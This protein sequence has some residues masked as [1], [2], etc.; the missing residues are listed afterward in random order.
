MMFLSGAIALPCGAVETW[1]KL[2]KRIKGQIF[3]LTVGVKL[4]LRDGLWANLA[5][6]SPKGH[7][8]VFSTGEDK[9]FKVIS[10]GTSFPIHTNL[11]DKTYFLTS[12]HVVANDQITEYNLE[13]DRFFAATKMYAEQKGNGNPDAKYKELLQ[14]INLSTKNPLQGPERQ[15]YETTVDAIWDTY[16][17]FLSRRADPGRVMFGK[18]SAQ[19]PVEHSI[20]YFL[21]APGPVSQKTLEPRIY[22]A[23][24]SDNEPDLAVLTVPITNLTC[25][26]FDTVPPEEGQ[27]IQVIGYP[28]ASDLIDKDSS[29]YFAPTFSS[30]RISRV[31]PRL[32]QVDA[33][34][35]NGSSGSPVVSLRGKVLG[36]VAV[37]AIVHK[38]EL[39]NFGGAVTIQSVQSFAPELFGKPGAGGGTR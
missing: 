33:P 18:Y 32:L 7:Y 31:A 21:H 8:P 36:V 35:T 6:L 13:C 30:G 3:D 39:P 17:N 1:E 23:A 16:D 25:M 29:D 20:A 9:G 37:R 12:G 4:R 38:T 27:E 5:D 19:A 14:I 11:H 22:K 15:L 26:E 24:K 2:D 10:F 34:I 28:T